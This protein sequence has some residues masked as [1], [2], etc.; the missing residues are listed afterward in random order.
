[1]LYLEPR[2]G[3]FPRGE[4]AVGFRKQSNSGFSQSIVFA[5]F[6]TL[7]YTF[8]Y[9]LLS[10][11]ISVSCLPQISPRFFRDFPWAALA[12]Q[13]PNGSQIIPYIYSNNHHLSTYIPTCTTRPP[14]PLSYLSTIVHTI[15]VCIIHLVLSR[16]EKLVFTQLVFNT[17]IF[18]N[19]FK[20]LFVFFGGSNHRR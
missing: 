5:I 19:V 14:K 2:C 11:L 4:T 6:K 10:V 8:S 9:V 7:H 16:T 1:M 17:N 12:T 3:F 13:W 20:F 18:E 15:A